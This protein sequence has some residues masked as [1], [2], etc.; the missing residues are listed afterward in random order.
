MCAKSSPPQWEGP[1]GMPCTN[2]IKCKLVRETPEYLQSFVVL[3]LVAEFREL[4]MLLLNWTYY[5]QSV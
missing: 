1:E 5:M 4:E 3:F 2:P